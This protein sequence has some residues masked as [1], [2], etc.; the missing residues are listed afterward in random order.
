MSEIQHD[1]FRFVAIRPPTLGDGEEP[2][3]VL[4]DQRPLNRT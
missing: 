4:M 1:V 2:E 3:E